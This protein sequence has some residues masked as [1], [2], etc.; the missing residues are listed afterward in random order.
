[1]EF[2]QIVLI[3]DVI[4]SSINNYTSTDNIEVYRKT[5]YNI[6]KRIRYSQTPE[7]VLIKDIS[8]IL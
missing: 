5:L 7:V 8:K 6:N 3:F 2:K 4:E 1:M